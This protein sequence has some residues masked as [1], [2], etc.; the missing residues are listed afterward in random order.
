MTHI[1]QVSENVHHCICYSLVGAQ[2][3]A[4]G[5]IAEITYD[6]I[7]LGREVKGILRAEIGSFVSYN[8]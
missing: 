6:Q 2:C 8:G 3:L 1:D 7:L 4:L 5:E